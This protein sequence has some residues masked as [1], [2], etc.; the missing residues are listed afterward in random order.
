MT[1]VIE[2][3]GALTVAA[4]TTFFDTARMEEVQVASFGDSP[5]APQVSVVVANYNHGRYA[6]EL[7]SALAGQQGNIS[8][9]L[10]LIDDGSSDGS[11]QEFV[12]AGRDIGIV[13]RVLKL[14]R[15]RGRSVARNVGILHAR[16]P[17]IA[18]TDADCVPH[19]SWLQE[20]IQ[21]FASP[22]V[23]IV[24]GTTLPRQDQ[25]QPFF[26]HFIEIT[27]FDGTFSTCNVLY[28]KEALI[29]SGG[30]DS[31]VVYWEDLDLGWR[32]RRMGVA[33]AFAPNATI[34]H[35]VV[36]LSPLQWLRWPAHFSFMPQKTARYPEYRGYLFLRF[37]VDKMHAL[38]DLALLGLGLSVA[39]H[40]ALGIL[41][42]PYLAAFSRQRG[43]TGKWPPVKALMHMAW[44][45]VAFLV[46][47][48]S[49][50]RYRSL[51]L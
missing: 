25:R 22:H 13:G 2:T 7:V 47:L 32:I 24:Q 30:F 35:Q 3:A 26:S 36:G 42:V 27:E 28:R 43:L 5:E 18:F 39:L 17:I 21:P 23:G 40:L 6:R 45:V 11:F 20:A 46:L 48:V 34:F 12:T 10:I 37:W 38:F 4:K 49:S 16:A 44:D 31:T 19:P 9:E 51:V 33:A 14:K 8:F 29:A 41:M 15:N 1:Y 50:I